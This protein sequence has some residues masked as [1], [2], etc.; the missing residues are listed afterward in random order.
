MVCEEGAI[1]GDHWS[2]SR[3]KGKKGGLGSLI[4]TGTHTPYGEKVG[5]MWRGRIDGVK[6]MFAWNSLLNSLRFGAENNP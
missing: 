6:K 5:N 3:V 2:V 4:V 1:P